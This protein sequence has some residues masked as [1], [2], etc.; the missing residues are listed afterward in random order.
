MEISGFSFSKIPRSKGIRS[1]GIVGFVN[2]IASLPKIKSMLYKNAAPRTKHNAQ[3]YKPSLTK[4]LTRLANSSTL[5]DLDF[6]N[7]SYELRP[8]HVIPMLQS[9][10]TGS[11]VLRQLDISGCERFMTSSE[12]IFFSATGDMLRTNSSLKRL[13]LPFPVYARCFLNALGVNSSLEI[14]VFKAEISCSWKTKSVDRDFLSPLCEALEH[15]NY[16][17]RN[18]VFPPSC[19]VDTQ[20]IG[21]NKLMDKVELY[22]KLNRAGR[23]SLKHGKFSTD[24]DWLNAILYDRNDLRVIHYFLRNN[25]CV[26]VPTVKRSRVEGKGAPQKRRRLDRLA[27]SRKK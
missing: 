24:Q 26:I 3:P 6:S 17:L 15:Q 20:R 16:T 21:H 27:K 11:S 2:T 9:L 25:P 13:V 1:K 7:W 14:L 10:K 5:V 12:N 19:L 8:T 22:L 23:A 18:V 4:A